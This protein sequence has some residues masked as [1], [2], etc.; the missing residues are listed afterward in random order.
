MNIAPPVSRRW[1]HVKFIPGPSANE[2]SVYFMAGTFGYWPSQS[3]WNGS[4]TH[5]STGA[6]PVVA[7]SSAGARL[8]FSQGPAGTRPAVA[9]NDRPGMPGAVESARCP[10]PPPLDVRWSAG[11]KRFVCSETAN[12]LQRLSVSKQPSS[13]PDR[14][15]AADSPGQRSVYYFEGNLPKAIGL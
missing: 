11:G 10:A 2:E 9:E 3:T 5:R 13:G 6:R 12:G 8:A 4:G 7:L 1:G 15:P 14:G